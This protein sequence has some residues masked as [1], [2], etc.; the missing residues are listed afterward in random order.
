V[1]GICCSKVDA[2]SFCEAC[3]AGKMHRKPFP[4]IEEI[5]SS[6]KLQLVHSD[7][8]G[9]IHTESFGG[10]KY[11]VTFMDDYSRCCAVYFMKQKSEVLEK[12]KEFE[13]AAT[14]EAGGSIGTLRTDNGGEYLSREFENYLN[15]KGIKHEL[16]V[17]Y[18]PQQNR[19]VKPNMYWAEA[20]SSTV[21]LRNQCLRQQLKKTKHPTSYGVEGN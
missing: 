20:I 19:V 1:K 18:S 3:L 21:Y 5:C 7:V 8:C 6:H 17:P 15:V 2:L 12:F 14:N 16:T 11:L 9:P 10:V 13:A 4:V